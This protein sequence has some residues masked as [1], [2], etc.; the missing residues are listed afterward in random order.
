MAK[1][2]SRVKITR[3]LYANRLKQVVE[4][5][6][7]AIASSLLIPLLGQTH[8]RGSMYQRVVYIIIQPLDSRQSRSY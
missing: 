4:T 3:W 6:G 5:G 8:I 1:N 2:L 7:I